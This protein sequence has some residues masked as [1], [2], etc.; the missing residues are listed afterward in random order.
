MVYE[1]IHC[2]T[3]HFRHTCINHCIN[4]HFS[5]IHL[6]PGDPATAMLGDLATE[7][8]IAALRIRMGPG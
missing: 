3:N 8:D 5:L 7:E 6:V 2:K 1:A 4:C